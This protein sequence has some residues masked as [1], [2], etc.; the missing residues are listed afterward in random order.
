MQLEAQI[1][2]A[3]TVNLNMRGKSMDIPGLNKSENKLFTKVQRIS[4]ANNKMNRLNFAN[5][6]SKTLG[7]RD[8]K[9]L[10]LEKRQTVI[11]VG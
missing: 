1:R 10:D 8:S 3:K 6:V 9:S 2:K 11:D 5:L 4:L 7:T